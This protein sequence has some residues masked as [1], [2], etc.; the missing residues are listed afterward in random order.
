MAHRE[1]DALT[2][3]L[4]QTGFGPYALARRVQPP[5]RGDHL[6]RILCGGSA[7]GAM[8]ERIVA[9]IR[10]E[11]A[12]REGCQADDLAGEITI[13]VLIDLIEARRLSRHAHPKSI[14]PVATC[15]LTESADDK[16]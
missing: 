6:S 15:N 9:A 2:L 5:M 13:G 14:A 12:A 8:L 11:I 10:R 1:P 3:L 7:S 4:K 16:G